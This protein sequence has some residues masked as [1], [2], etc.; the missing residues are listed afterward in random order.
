MKLKHMLIKCKQHTME[1][2]LSALPLHTQIL[3]L[4]QV[5]VRIWAISREFHLIQKIASA[6]LL[7]FPMPGTMK[8]KITI[9]IIQASYLQESRSDISQLWFGETLAKSD[10]VFLK[11]SLFA[12]TLLQVTS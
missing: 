12:D 11:T 3:Q 6:Q 5:K 2:H 10:A 9:L 8:L 1:E 4:A 7:V